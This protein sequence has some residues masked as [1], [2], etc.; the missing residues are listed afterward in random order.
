[1]EIKIREHWNNKL[2][3]YMVLWSYKENHPHILRTQIIFKLFW[4]WNYISKS[5]ITK[6]NQ[7]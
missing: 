2:Y 7:H 4:I 6:I 3:I 1:M 5:H